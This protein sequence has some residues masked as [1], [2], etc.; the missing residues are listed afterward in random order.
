VTRTVAGCVGALLLL[1]ACSGR[2]DEWYDQTSADDAARDAY[3]ADQKYH[4]ISESEAKQNWAL[5]KAIER[6]EGRIGVETKGEELQN[7]LGQ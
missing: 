5:N 1:A 7:K 2:R 6:T 4:G 3:V